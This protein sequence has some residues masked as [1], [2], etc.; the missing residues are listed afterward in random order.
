LV[1]AALISLPSGAL[2]RRF[3]RS[4]GVLLG[5]FF[6]FVGG[7]GGFVA[8]E[9]G[10]ATAGP[11]LFVACFLVGVS[12]GLGQFYRFAASEMCGDAVDERASAVT[13]VLAGGLIAAFAGP[14][15]SIHTRRLIIDLGFFNWR[16]ADFSG[17]FAL[18]ALTNVFNAV[19][20]STVRFTPEAASPLARNREDGDDDDASSIEEL[21]RPLAPPP[22]EE[23]SPLTTTTTTT[24]GKK[25]RRA[26]EILSGLEGAC[27]VGTAALAHTAMVMLMSPLTI[28]MQ[29]SDIS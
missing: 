11:E 8:L 4:R 25:P 6:G 9:G 7:V 19:V 13:L 29:A 18:V 17:C 2:F 21:S 20:N 5:C 3:G 1:G 27:A 28:A 12:Q 22:P 24:T 23:S 14:E 15:A 10:R 16:G 26:W